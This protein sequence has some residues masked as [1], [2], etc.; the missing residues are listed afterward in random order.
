MSDKTAW[1][2]HGQQLWDSRWGRRDP[3]DPAKE[4]ECA[5]IP[6]WVYCVRLLGAKMEIREKTLRRLASAL[7]FSRERGGPCSPPAFLK[8]R[9]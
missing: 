9:N 3:L 7:R 8:G 1:E 2:G 4:K 6:R 5:G